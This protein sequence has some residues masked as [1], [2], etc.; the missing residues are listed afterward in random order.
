MDQNQTLKN[1][2]KRLNN[3][4][5]ESER[6]NAENTVNYFFHFLLI[7][8]KFKVKN[9]VMENARS[10][11][12]A[13]FRPNHQE[14]FNQERILSTKRKESK[15]HLESDDQESF[16]DDYDRNRNLYKND[17][18]RRTS[19]QMQNSTSRSFEDF[20]GSKKGL[21]QHE[22]ASHKAKHRVDGIVSHRA[23][24]K[25]GKEE[26]SWK[27]YQGKKSFSAKK[28]LRD[29]ENQRSWENRTG[30][31]IGWE[32]YE[33]Q[34]E[35]RRTLGLTKKAREEEIIEK[36]EEDDIDNDINDENEDEYFKKYLGNREL[37]MEKEE[38]NTR[39][40]MGTLKKEIFSLDNEIY[41]IQKLIKEELES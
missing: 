37:D 20:S 39:P 6:L 8:P 1:L 40:M 13:T 21:S 4:L 5:E 41:E 25:L 16:E 31:T 14:D 17:K 2:N 11:A 19:N 27:N 12:R 35:G 30:K 24:H 32:D 18:E 38:E 36:D 9:L 26:E 22:I 3:Q 15:L 10:S 33:G 7:Y 34:V 28:D 29:H 23:S